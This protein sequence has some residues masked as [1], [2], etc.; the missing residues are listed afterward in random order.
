MLG[1][2]KNSFKFKIIFL[3]TGIALV[4]SIPAFYIYYTTEKKQLYDILEVQITQLVHRF[5][6]A[7]NN[8]VRYNNYYNI[9]DDIMDTFDY[10]K[11]TENETGSLFKIQSIVVTDLKGMIYGHSN[12]EKFPLL[13]P[14]KHFLLSSGQFEKKEYIKTILHWNKKN[15]HIEVRA[16]VLFESEVVG[17]IFMDIN[18]VILKKE[19]QQLRLHIATIFLILLIV[20]ISIIY[21][22]S[23]WIEKPLS[24]IMQGIEKLGSGQLD[25]PE[26]KNRGDEFQTLASALTEADHNI[27]EKTQ[28]LI[29]YQNELEN[30]VKA[31]TLELQEKANDLNDTLEKLTHSQA[32]LIETEKMSALGSLV[33]GVAHEVNTPIG[34]SLTGITHIQA[35]TREIIKALENENLGKNALEDYLD[36][37]DK[38]ADSMHLSLV[39][40]ANLIRSFKQVAVDQHVEEKRLF[41]LKEYYDEVLLSLHNKIKH[42]RLKVCNRIDN[43][44]MLNSYAGIFSQ[45]LTNLIMNSLIHAFNDDD[46]GEIDIYGNFK[47]HNLNI[48]YTDNGKGIDEKII[49]NIF[50]PFFTTRLGKGGSGLGLNIIFNLITHKLKG[51]IQCKNRTSGG[52]KFIITIPESEII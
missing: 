27:H 29:Q 34:V 50:E 4:S 16:P 7:I 9:S 18:A 25:Y 14:Y 30:K 46:E 36:M 48:T 13:T 12:P 22:I 49:N 38:M 19:E 17:F 51:Q 26:L 20:I 39:N 3:L 33:A 5:S 32:Q 35:E 24:T 45:I 8:D 37:I 10:S 44:I 42:T 28:L 11:I 23:N 31:R 2:I 43:N 15:Q 1:K 52:V 40:A 47:N 41:D 21:L 6:L